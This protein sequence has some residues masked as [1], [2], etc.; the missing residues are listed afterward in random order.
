LRG[1]SEQQRATAS[2]SE[3][4]PMHLWQQRIIGYFLIYQ[5]FI[6]LLLAVAAVAGVYTPLGKKSKKIH[7]IMEKPPLVKK[8]YSG[9][10]IRI[11]VQK[12][13]NIIKKI[14]RKLL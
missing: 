11:P 12:V 3:Q 7:G 1:N 13:I 9:V 2:N 14:R 10:E 5:L 6:Y 8:W 4:Q